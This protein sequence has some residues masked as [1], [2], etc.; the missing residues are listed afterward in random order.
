MR[1]KTKEFS[2]VVGFITPTKNWSK[3]RQEEYKLRQEER[4]LREWWYYLKGEII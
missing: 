3:E 4:K 2:R 1:V